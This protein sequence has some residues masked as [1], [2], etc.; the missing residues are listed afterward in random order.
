MKGYASKASEAG[1]I[2]NISRQLNS[3]FEVAGKEANNITNEQAVNIVLDPAKKVYTKQLQK[4]LN[5]FKKLY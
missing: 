3:I 1:K 5:H 4:S 2:L